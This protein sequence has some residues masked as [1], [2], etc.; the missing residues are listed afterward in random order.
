M[1]AVRVK[2]NH[3]MNKVHVLWHTSRLL[4][5]YSVHREFSFM[6]LVIIIILLLNYDMA[7]NVEWPDSKA[8]FFYKHD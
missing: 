6:P 3:G 8:N 2:L 5:M 4:C 7:G 1:A